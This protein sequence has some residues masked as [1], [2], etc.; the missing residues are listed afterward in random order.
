MQAQELGHFAICFGRVSGAKGGF[1]GP[2][3]VGHKFMHQLN[4]VS[5]EHLVFRLHL[6]LRPF[7]LA[8]RGWWCSIA[9]S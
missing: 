7:V 5:N 3:F 2:S 6:F 4:T 9:S 1:M 8:G